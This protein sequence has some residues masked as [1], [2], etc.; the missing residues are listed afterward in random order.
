MVAE[1][2]GF[3]RIEGR[4][5]LVDARHVSVNGETLEAD[6]ILI[7]SGAAP[8]IP[9]IPGLAEAD[10]LTNESAFELEELPAS[11]IVL[12]GRFVALESA[13]TFARFGVEVTVLQRSPRILPDEMPDLTDAL[14][15]F[16]EDEGVEAV[17]GVAVDRISSRAGGVEV[18][19]EVDGA[20]RTFRASRV[21]VATGRRP[22]TRDMGL[23]QAGTEVDGGG[24]VAVDATLETTVEGV[25]A[26]GDV[27]GGPMYVYTAAYEGPLAV[28][29]ALAEGPPRERDYAGPPRCCR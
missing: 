3:R 15:G 18:E 13:Q 19:A 27:I 6:R 22:N 24:F 20:Q 11:L 9:P 26:A 2:P 8:R 5:R 21:L 28:E 29:N 1:L 12:G 23:R 4:A 10:Y 14:S 7:A 25:Y 17:T 16:L